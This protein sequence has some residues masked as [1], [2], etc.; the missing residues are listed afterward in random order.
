MDKKSWMILISRCVR[1]HLFGGLQTRECTP[2]IDQKSSSKLRRHRIHFL[3]WNQMFSAKKANKFPALMQNGLSFVHTCGQFKSISFAA[4]HLIFLQK[5]GP[6]KICRLQSTKT[7]YRF[8][9]IV[10]KRS[11]LTNKELYFINIHRKYEQEQCSDR[12]SYSNEDSFN[13]LWV[14]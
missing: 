7:K 8:A 3:Q 1:H 14:F 10:K 4:C 11:G 9:F 13:W 6:R 12:C 2:F 5:N